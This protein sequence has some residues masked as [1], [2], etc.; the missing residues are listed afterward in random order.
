MDTTFFRSFFVGNASL[1]E[2]VTIQPLDFDGQTHVIV[3]ELGHG[4]AG[5]R[6]G[7]RTV[8]EGN[9]VAT[10]YLQYMSVLFYPRDEQCRLWLSV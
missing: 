4:A 10:T 2:P 6:P 5:E 1:S 9:W 3:S 8:K 7:V